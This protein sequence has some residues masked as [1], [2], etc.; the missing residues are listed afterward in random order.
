MVEATQGVTQ[1]LAG[2]IDRAETAI[3]LRCALAIRGIDGN[4]HGVSVGRFGSAIAL[5]ARRGLRVWNR[6][7]GLRAGDEELLDEI[8][9]WYRQLGVHPS[10]DI[11]PGLCSPELRAALAARGFAQLHFDSVLYADPSSLELAEEEAVA[12]RRA[13]D[14]IDLFVD[15][16]VRA[17]EYGDSLRP[18]FADVYGRPDPDRRLYLAI[19][20]R[21]VA[22]VA[23]LELALEPEGRAATL[24]NAATLRD[25]RRR[26]CQR[27]LLI[28]RLAEAEQLGC[29]LVISQTEVSHQS[30]RNMERLGL[31][32]AYTKAVWIDPATRPAE[33]V[34]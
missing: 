29:D 32:L 9:D 23:V 26:G 10:I 15:T 11:V 25:H 27:A 18:L 6:L 13:E 24:S 28:R 21:Q 2:R 4:P 17:Y 8:V 31:Q 33:P 1:A 16:Y 7:L 12:V 14:E 19:C 30:Q 22:G 20:D 34:V 5:A 3:A